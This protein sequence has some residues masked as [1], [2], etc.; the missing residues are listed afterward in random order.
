MLDWNGLANIR[1]HVPRLTHLR[2]GPTEEID[3]CDLFV[4]APSL[5]SVYI[6][7]D[8]NVGIQLPFEQ[9]QFLKIS[10]AFAEHAVPVLQRCT[11]VEAL[12]LDNIGQY[13]GIGYVPRVEMPRVEILNVVVHDEHDVSFIFQH[14]LLSRLSS[15][16]VTVNIESECDYIHYSMPHW[17]VWEDVS[18]I[19]DFFSTCSCVLTTLHVQNLPTTDI[20]LLDLLSLLP[21]LR[22]LLVR[23]LGQRTIGADTLSN[24]TITSTF[25]W[26]LFTLPI[27]L[28]QL[29][30]LT[31]Y[32]QLHLF[33]AQALVEL[34]SARRVAGRPKELV[35]I[36][37]LR[38]I[39]V[40]LEGSGD[41]PT[42]LEQLKPFVDEGLRVEI[43]R[44]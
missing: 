26:R 31:L 4:D 21:L 2:L 32:A 14:L 11:T 28:P 24:R 25:L 12:E 5:K 15:L 40:E 23:D 30:D 35:G 3:P 37:E 38:S 18:R 36:T 41:L 8:S 33:D 27:I 7:P 42:E 13:I 17:R 44:S 22:E 43:S 9:L 29:V 1:G 6:I 20:H 10:T 19:R 34:V 16:S 39:E